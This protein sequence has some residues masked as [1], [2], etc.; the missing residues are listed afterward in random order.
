M[1]M[2]KRLQKHISRVPITPEL[3]QVKYEIQMKSPVMLQELFP[4]EG[5]RR[6]I[7]E[8]INM[9]AAM[10][11]KNQKKATWAVQEADETFSTELRTGKVQILNEAEIEEAILT[12]NMAFNRT[13]L[14]FNL[15]SPSTKVRLIHDFTREVHGTTLSLEILSGDNGLGSLVEAGFSFRIHT[16]IRSYDI[17]K[18]YTQI[19]VEGPFLWAS[20]NIWFEDVLKQKGPMVVIREALSFGNPAAGLIVELLVYLFI[21]S[22]IEEEDVRDLISSSRYSGT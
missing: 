7:E 2:M 10:L 4:V 1:K 11:R 21:D 17:A 6:R 8:A 5:N 16:F 15:D 22:E 13:D 18:C 19:A 9:T 14:V 20:L 12:K 3:F